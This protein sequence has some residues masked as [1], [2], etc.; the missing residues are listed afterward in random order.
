MNIKK[1]IPVFIVIVV[2][3]FIMAYIFIPKNSTQ[4]QEVSYS[5]SL[6]DRIAKAAEIEAQEELLH[7]SNIYESESYAV[8]K[9]YESIEKAGISNART[10]L[11]LS[12]KTT[13][14][15][16]LLQDEALSTPDKIFEKDGYIYVIGSDYQSSAISGLNIMRYKLTSDMIET[17]QTINLDD[18]DKFKISS[19]CYARPEL[20][21]DPY[22]Q[23]ISSVY[24]NVYNYKDDT[25]MERVGTSFQSVDPDRD[26][27]AKI[28]FVTEDETYSDR[29]IE[30]KISSDN[31][32]DLSS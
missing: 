12:D 19:A 4:Q 21:N 7:E 2:V 25:F 29:D 22:S 3:I 18:N 14:K 32:Y 11:I 27:S 28:F 17:V 15:R 1:C 10:W 6:D 5:Y 20:I 24:F 31:T 26:I 8:D 9:Y 13:G 16:I 30:F 23:E